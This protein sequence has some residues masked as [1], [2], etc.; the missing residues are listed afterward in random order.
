MFAASSLAVVDGVVIGA[1]VV[2]VLAFA[3]AA[4]AAAFW[5]VKGK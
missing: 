1:H 4:T 5:G 3:A 2:V